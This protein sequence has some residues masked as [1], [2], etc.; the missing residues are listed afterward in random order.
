[1]H[2]TLIDWLIIAGYFIFNLAIGIYYHRKA[3]GSVDDYFVSGRSVTWWL[4]GTSMVATTFAADTP[5]AVTGLVAKNGIAGNWVWW[6]MVMSGMLTVFFYA[7]LWRRAGVL[8]DVE[9]AE[10][11]YA[12]KPAAFLR[13]F[14]AFYLGIMNFIVMGWVN[15]A[16]I[17][18]LMGILG[19]EKL[20]YRLDSA[21]IR[22]GPLRVSP[23]AVCLA[24]SY[25]HG[26]DNSCVA[27]RHAAYKAGA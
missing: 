14:R 17:K 7:K 11:R 8:T 2:L 27:H 25:Y 4:A 23:Q 19:I 1:M 6:S 3:T 18:I 24:R 9:F 26:S 16:M 13:G 12:G 20:L 10:I 22:H 21:S 15:L 5:L